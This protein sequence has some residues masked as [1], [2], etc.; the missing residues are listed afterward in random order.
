VEIA[1]SLLR[2]ALE[3]GASRLEIEV[4]RSED[5]FVEFS[6]HFDG[7]PI[8][9]DQR[10]FDFDATKALPELKGRTLWW[11][12]TALL[13]NR[14]GLALKRDETREPNAEKAGSTFIMHLPTVS[15]QKEGNETAAS[16]AS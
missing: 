3:R 8:E 16:E 14:G 15:A 7:K 10:I 1:K 5:A 13:R 6:I 2:T 4:L 11:C 9:P 12:R